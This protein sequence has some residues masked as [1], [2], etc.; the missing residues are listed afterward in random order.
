MYCNR[1][2]AHVND[3]RAVF[4]VLEIIVPTVIVADVVHAL[5]T[6]TAQGTG[7]V[8]GLQLGTGFVFDALVEVGQLFGVGRV[9][10]Q[11][12]RRGLRGSA[13]GRG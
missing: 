7:V 11:A 1:S 10:G 12:V 2:V 3:F 5:D 4:V 13:S 8:Q 9:V 6:S